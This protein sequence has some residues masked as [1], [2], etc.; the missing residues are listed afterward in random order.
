MKQSEFYTEYKMGGWYG[1]HRK[2]GQSY[3]PVSTRDAAMSGVRRQF[4]GK[5]TAKKVDLPTNRVALVLDRSG[6]MNNI[7][8]EA[9]AAINRN[10]DTIAKNSK[11]F[12]QRTKVNVFTFADHV[13][14]VITDADPSTSRLGSVNSDGSTA[15]FDATTAAIEELKRQSAYDK[16]TSFLVVVVTDGYENASRHSNRNGIQ[17]EIR[18]LQATDLWTFAFLAPPGNRQVVA[19]QF[20]VPAGN[21]AE[22]EATSLGVTQFANLNNSSLNT[23]YASSAKGITSTQSFYTDLSGLNSKTVKK[24]LDDLS[25]TV[26]VLPVD[27]EQDIRSFVESRLGQYRP[28]TAFYQLTKDEKKVQDYKDVLVMEKGKRAVYGGPDARTVLGIPEGNLSIKPGNHGNWDIF[29]QSNS[30][31]RKLVRGTK[32]LVKVV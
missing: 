12:G 30:N 14:Q 13:S 3:G 21:V 29:L 22:W 32:L 23:Y 11:K 10:I 27:K 15:L 28:G 19:D 5:K 24:N 25:S 16:K 31:N 20:G 4:N 8:Q 9:V 7:M 26:R 18:R 17:S 2:T 1:Y 6:S